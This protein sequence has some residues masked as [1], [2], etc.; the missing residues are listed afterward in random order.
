MRYSL[1]SIQML[2][3]ELTDLEAAGKFNNESEAFGWELR[4]AQVALRR[5]SRLLKEYYENEEL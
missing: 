4:D 1:D 3:N 2:I 5:L